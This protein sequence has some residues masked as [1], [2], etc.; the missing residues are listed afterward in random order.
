MTHPVIFRGPALPAPAIRWP[1]SE[2]SEVEGPQ[3]NTKGLDVDCA[4]YAGK[5]LEGHW[6]VVD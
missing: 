3:K 2:R 6:L 1:G 4:G 5:C